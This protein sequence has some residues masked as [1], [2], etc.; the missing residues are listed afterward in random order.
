MNTKFHKNQYW[1]NSIC[2]RHLHFLHT[3]LL[4]FVAYLVTVYFITHF[5]EPSLEWL[6]NEQLDGI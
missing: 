5:T 2:A 4:L 3:Y 1:S 6:V